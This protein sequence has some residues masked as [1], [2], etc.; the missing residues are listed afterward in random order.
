[1]GL[2]KPETGEKRALKCVWEGDGSSGERGGAACGGVERRRQGCGMRAALP[3]A[4]WH[5]GFVFKSKK[6]GFCSCCPS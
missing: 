3:G 1:M 4:C 2:I 6:R 5:P